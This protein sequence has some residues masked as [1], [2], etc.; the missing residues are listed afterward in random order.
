MGN[1]GFDVIKLIITILYMLSLGASGAM[2]IWWIV[3]L[4]KRDADKAKRKKVA[5]FVVGLGILSGVLLVVHMAVA[6]AQYT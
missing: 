2:F 1:M 6:V 4:V 5:A 3:L